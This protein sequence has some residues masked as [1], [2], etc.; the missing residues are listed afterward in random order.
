MWEAVYIQGMWFLA[1]QH[2]LGVISPGPTM[3]VIIANSIDNRIK[4]LKT[5][6]GA[7]VGSF[8]VKFLSIVG[9][10]LIIRQSP[11][12]FD[13]VKIF[14]GLYLIFLG[15]LFLKNAYRD[16]KNYQD[17]HV[18][19]IKDNSNLDRR[20]FLVGFLVNMTNPLASVRFVVI[21]AT[22]ITPDMPLP[23]QLSYL[24]VLASISIVIY[25]VISLF[26]SSERIQH[27]L[28]RFRFIVNAILGTT[29]AYWGVKCFLVSPLLTST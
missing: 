10:A 28:T 17:H 1:M 27:F 24:V 13:A 2:F 25:S 7:V 22:A 5:V 23:M 3:A 8:T 12:L 26:F 4:G 11:V 19:S 16:W 18:T 21:F 29:M 6:L 9:L 20:P 14:G 15:L